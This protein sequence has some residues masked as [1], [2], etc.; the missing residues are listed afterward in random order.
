MGSHERV[1]ELLV[2]SGAYTDLDT[3][4]ILHS[5]NLGIYFINAE[6]LLFDGDK[7]KQYANVPTSIPLI[8]YAIQQA[9][10]EPQFKEVITMLADYSADVHGKGTSVISGGQRR[11]WIFSAAVAHQ[12][13]KPHVSL[14]KHGE[15][16]EIVDANQNVQEMTISSKP[17]SA[18]YAVHVSDLLTTGSSTFD[19]RNAEPTGWVP[20]LRAAGATTDTMYSVVS[21][22][23]GGE[24]NL[25]RG[26]VTAISLV[27]ID[28]EF[29]ERYA[30]NKKTACAYFD[31]PRAWSEAYMREHGIDQFVAAFAPEKMVKD[32]RAVSF[33]HVYNEVLTEPRTGR[34]TLMDELQQ[35]ILQRY[36]VDILKLLET[37]LT[38]K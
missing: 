22:R 35:K 2:K 7:W 6:N 23:E 18:M 28:A 37:S 14:F 5:G 15:V 29:L 4:V 24:Q 17:L 30:T 38:E 19:D 26:G 1:S 27:S 32:Q 31:N 25:Q 34:E 21:R 9:K 10:D 13:E 36:K 16:I 8:K 20:Q 12:L 33:L 3:P 11:D